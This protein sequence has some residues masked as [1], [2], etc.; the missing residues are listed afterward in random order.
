MKSIAAVAQ[1]AVA[2][3][4]SLAANTTVAPLATTTLV[5]VTTPYAPGSC[6]EAEAQVPGAQAKEFVLGFLQGI[7]SDEA[8]AAHCMKG[9]KTAAS[10]FVVVLGCI[11]QHDLGAA[12]PV[13]MSAVGA[14]VPVVQTCRAAA[15]EVQDLAYDLI[16]LTPDGVKA[17]IEDHYGEILLQVSQTRASFEQGDFDD[18]GKQIGA[19]IHKIIE[20][21]AEAPTL[22]VPATTTAPRRHHANTTEAP[23]SNATV[24][25]PATTT[26]VPTT[27]TAAEAEV[28]GEQAK[29]FVLGFLRG[30]LSD[31]TDAGHCMKGG[32]KATSVF[33]VVLGCIKQHDLG[34][35]VPALMSAVP[36]LVPVVGMCQAAASEVQNLADGLNSLSPQGVKA[37]IEDHYGEILVQVSETATSIE[38]GDFDDV[39]KQVGGIIHQIV[40]AGVAPTLIV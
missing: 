37:Y 23:S 29:E 20:A 34:A 22:A 28:P 30:I 10:A 32:K 14:L 25:P 16:G 4:A 11:V 2:L 6:T 36:A 21:N 13:L 26:D 17:Y 39:G 31:E 1:L 5:P 8:D 3:S 33:V 15:S 27:C 24:S 9:G 40:E 7:L 35:A 38:Q 19:I 18:V 12:A